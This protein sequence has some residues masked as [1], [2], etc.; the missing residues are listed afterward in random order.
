[1]PVTMTAFIVQLFL[2]QGLRGRYER[3]WAILAVIL[4]LAAAWATRMTKFF[5]DNGFPAL[6][7]LKLLPP[8]HNIIVLLRRLNIE[9][10]IAAEAAPTGRSV[11]LL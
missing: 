5:C 6:A 4:R 8:G 11:R 3:T 7:A 1:M 10:I 2:K 9:R